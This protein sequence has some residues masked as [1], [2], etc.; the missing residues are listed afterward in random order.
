M[1]THRS[2]NGYILIEATVAIV[3]LGIS[4][5]TING[6]VR[7]AI[8]TRGQS[9][10]Y[11]Q[12]HLLMEAFLAEKELQPLVF[13]DNGEGTFNDGSGRYSYVYSV[14]PVALPVP[15]F[16]PRATAA[17]EAMPPFRFDKTT[18]RLVRISITTFWTRGQ[19][20][21][22]ETMEVLVSQDQLYVPQAQRVAQ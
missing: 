16:P 5:L 21:F 18:D 20:Q 19:M 13:V 12:V 3:V 22:E 10:D 1:S 17:G 8:L 4:A 14:R 2:Q 11:T 7:Q 15:N 9:Q 6:A